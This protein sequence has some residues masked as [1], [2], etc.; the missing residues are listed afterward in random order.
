MGRQRTNQITVAGGVKQPGT[1]QVPR[2][3]SCL[4]LALLKAGG[5]SDDGGPNIEIRRTP[6]GL[7]PPGTPM[8]PEVFHINLAEAA[9]HANRLYPLADGDVVQV[10]RRVLEPVYVF[11]LVTKSGDYRMP[12]NQDLTVLDALAMAGNKTQYLADEIVVTRHMPGH[13]TPLHIKVSIA[14]AKRNPEA[15]ILLVPGD[16]VEIEDTLLTAGVRTFKD[17][18]HGLSLAPAIAM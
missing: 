9:Q 4:L 16:T 13:D 3:S 14:E 15:N 1:V 6:K 7:A 2:G 18:F 12:L 11:G 8:A 10:E 5:L 17:F